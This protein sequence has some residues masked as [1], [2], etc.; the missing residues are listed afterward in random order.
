MLTVN[1]IAGQRMNVEAMITPAGNCGCL[2]AQQGKPIKLKHDQRIEAD[3][4]DR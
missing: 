1:G 2:Y 3:R 4:A